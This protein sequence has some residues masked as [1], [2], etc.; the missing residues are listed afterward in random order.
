MSGQSITTVYTPLG[1]VVLVNAIGGGGGSSSSDVAVNSTTTNATPVTLAS[2]TLPDDSCATLV[3]FVRARNAAR[4]A[5]KTWALSRTANRPP[6]GAT[7]ARPEVTVQPVDFGPGADPGWLCEIDL[8][9]NQLRVRGTGAAAATVFWSVN[10]QAYSSAASAPPPVVAA[11][12]VTG[13]SPSIGVNLA[14]GVVTI[15]GTNFTAGASATVGGVALTGVTFVNTT[16]LTATLP[17]TTAGALA[18][19]VTTPSGTNSLAAAFYSLDVAGLGYSLWHS[20]AGVTAAAGLVSVLA[21]QG[22]SARNVSAGGGDEPTLIAADA[23][24][25]GRPTLNLAGGKYLKSAT[26]TISQPVTSFAVANTEGAQAALPEYVADGFS[27]LLAISRNGGGATAEIYQ[28]SGINPPGDLATKQIVTALYKSG[29]NN[30][31]A[32]VSSHTEVAGTVGTNTPAGRT[33]GASAGN[34]FRS[35][36]KFAL[37]LDV[38]GELTLAQRTANRNTLGLYYAKTIAP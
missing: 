35:R 17:A 29:A 23:A 2:H 30:G 31:R 5:I 6:G 10:S 19:A 4:T 3:A 16:T 9:G 15:E 1:G 24:Y 32:S 20:G 22:P 11:P 12:T 14:G 8:V 21:D 13:V 37:L 38:Y 34:A 7:W 33:I 18:V 36:G 28:A 26:Y 25:N 27:D